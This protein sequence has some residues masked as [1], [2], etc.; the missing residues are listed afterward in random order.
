MHWPVPGASRL[1]LV[2]LT[3]VWP[4]T[5]AFTHF[6]IATVDADLV[7]PSTPRDAQDLLNN[8]LDDEAYYTALLHR[9]IAV[10]GALCRL[11]QVLPHL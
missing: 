3:V 9:T 6:A 4:W 2:L 5:I 1:V 8:T 7:L 11:E 10:C